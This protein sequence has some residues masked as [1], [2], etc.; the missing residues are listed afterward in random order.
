MSVMVDVAIA[1]LRHQ[2]GGVGGV[3][4]LVFMVSVVAAMAVVL[5]MVAVTVALLAV[6][7]TNGGDSPFFCGGGV[8]VMAVVWGCR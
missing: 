3:G 2:V 7:A 6:I 5:D 8:L 4:A 1:G